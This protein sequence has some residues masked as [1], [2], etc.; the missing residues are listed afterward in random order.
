[1]TSIIPDVN[2]VSKFESNAIMLTSIFGKNIYFPGQFDPNTT[3]GLILK[4]F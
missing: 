4:K 1:M 3:K 2:K